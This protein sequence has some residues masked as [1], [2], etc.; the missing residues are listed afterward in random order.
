MRQRFE[1]PG[2]PV[3]WQV[4]IRKSKPT[5]TYLEM[6]AW[7]AQVSAYL[8]SLWQGPPIDTIVSLDTIFW[9]P[10]PEH[11]PQKLQRAVE[12]FK[13]TQLGKKPDLDNYRK[14]CTD[15]CQGILFH[16]DSQVVD[17]YMRK[18][19]LEPPAIEGYT[20]IEIQDYPTLEDY[21]S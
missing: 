1:I 5:P 16:N 18:N 19:Y 13:F 2:T 7:Q 12:K 21:E 10:W 4:W 3:P 15:A 17:G 20:V 14:A 6:Q 8:R 9:L 11:G